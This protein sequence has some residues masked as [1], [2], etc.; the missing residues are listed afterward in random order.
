ME[1][2]AEFKQYDF[3]IILDLEYDR[4]IIFFARFPIDKIYKKG[5]INLSDGSRLLFLWEIET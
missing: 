3:S 4:S 5:I 1:A 2:V